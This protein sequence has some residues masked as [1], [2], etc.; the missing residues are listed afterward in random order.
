MCTPIGSIFSIKQTVI[1]LDSLSLTTSSSSSSHP[2]TD[3]STRIWPIRLTDI[4]LVAI[5]SSSSSLNTAPPP[6]PPMVYAGL[7][8]TGYPRSRA[9]FLASSTEYASSLFGI[10]TP[11][12][13][14][15]FLN[16]SLSS[17]LSIASACTPM[18]LQPNFL[19][20]P[21]FANSLDRLSPVWPPRF[22]KRASGLSFS[23]IEVS[24]ST[25]SG[26]I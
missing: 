17:P 13:F 8:I 23:I 15:V 12:L 11:S 7:I 9:I 5:T 22:G 4:P 21:F 16:A 10:G 2:N 6:V 3:S 26:S 1:L 14:I 18:I 19:S 20:T 24:L 25:L